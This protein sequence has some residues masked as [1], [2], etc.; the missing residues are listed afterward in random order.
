MSHRGADGISLAQV[1]PHRFGF[2]R[3]FDDHKLAIALFHLYRLGRRSQAFM[4]R[5]PSHL[6]KFC[7]TYRAGANRDRRPL[8]IEIRHGVLHFTLGLAFHAIGFHTLTFI[9]VIARL[10][11]RVR[12]RNSMT[13]LQIFLLVMFFQVFNHIPY[14]LGLVCF[15]D[16]QDIA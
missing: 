4:G 10:L 11:R 7:P 6:I 8:G 13:V 3:R 15:T 2:G 5:C 1:A 9:S 12:Q 16:H 14:P